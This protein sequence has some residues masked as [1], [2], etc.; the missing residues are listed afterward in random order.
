VTE[1]YPIF[2]SS[3]FSNAGPLPG[4]DFQLYGAGLTIALSERFAMG[5]NQG[6]YADAHISHNP[7]PGQDF[8]GNRKGWLNLGGFFQYTL[9]EDV[10][11]QFLLTGGLRW[12]AP[13]GSTEVFQGHGPA[14]LGTYLTVGK[15]LGQFHVLAVTGYHFPAGP[16]S[17]STNAFYANFHLDRQMFGWLYPVLELNWTYHVT[18]VNPDL[19]TRRG[20]ID[21]GNFESS[22][23]ILALGVGA[24]AVI[25]RDRLEL[26]AIY[27]TPLATQRDFNFNSLMVKL[28]LRY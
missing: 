9:V 1:L 13:C 6:G 5:L 28:V 3:W 7:I 10:P 22:G 26:G 24:N 4:G 23:N 19:V 2:G 17:D 27:G 12:E 21:F 11:N 8:G 20:F 16:G 18:R 14:Q 15:E 25:V